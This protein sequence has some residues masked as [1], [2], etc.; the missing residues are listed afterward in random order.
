M[1]WIISWGADNKEYWRV[2]P[3]KTSIFVFS[4]CD[5]IHSQIS[6][7]QLIRKYVFIFIIMFCASNILY[8]ASNLEIK[9]LN[10]S[11]VYYYPS[12]QLTQSSNLQKNI[13]WQQSVEKLISKQGKSL[14]KN[15]KTSPWIWD[16]IDRKW[17]QKLSCWIY[18][19]SVRRE[20]QELISNIFGCLTTITHDWSDWS[21]GQGT[22]LVSSLWPGYNTSLSTTDQRTGL[23]KHGIS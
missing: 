12:S 18:P 16:T 9:V 5:V 2:S 11:V 14:L 1:S 8:R 20:S 6:V 4:C 19:L 3:D 13:L 23:S 7:F 10:H 17:M 22:T 21:V 15:L